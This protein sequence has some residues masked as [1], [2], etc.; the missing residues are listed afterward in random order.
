[1]TRSFVA[2]FLFLLTAIIICSCEHSGEQ[3]SLGQICGGC[4]RYVKGF[5]ITGVTNDVL[6]TFTNGRIE[7]A[8]DCMK[9]CQQNWNTCTDW[10]WKYTDGSGKRTCTL[11]SNFN[12]PLGV[13]IGVD[14]NTSTNVGVIGGNPQV[15]GLV[16]HCQLFDRYGNV[17][18][19]DHEC[20][21][22]PLW[23]LDNNQFLC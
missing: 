12:L 8:C 4:I 19:T 17:T 20:V 9:K 2:L 13:T 6:Y 22:G 3:D 11:Y 7:T 10:V 15:G 14:L 5:D 21:S 1:M 23:A 16:P 18:G